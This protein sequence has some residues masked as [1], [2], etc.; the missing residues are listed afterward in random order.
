MPGFS[1]ERW[2]FRHKPSTLQRRKIHHPGAFRQTDT[3]K[4]GVQLELLAI[5]VE[6]RPVV[7][8]LGSPP[9]CKALGKQGPKERLGLPLG[10]E[11]IHIAHPTTLGASQ[12]GQGRPFERC[13][14]DTQLV[15]E[16]PDL[17]N[18]SKRSMA[19][20]SAGGSG[21]HQ[22]QGVLLPQLALQEGLGGAGADAPVE[23]QVPGKLQRPSPIH[24]AAPRLERCRKGAGQHP[25]QR[26][27]PGKSW[28]VQALEAKSHEQVPL[29]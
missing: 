19:K 29:R 11:D 1:Q 3:G 5:P 9:S 17:P 25:Q 20:R 21:A 18:Q 24:G 27:V 15:G 22:R 2:N 14:G 8:G 26:G 16:A 10:D 6:Q 23:A 7:R 12:G 4:V 28:R 13:P